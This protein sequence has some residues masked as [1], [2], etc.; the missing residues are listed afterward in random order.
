LKP[1]PDKLKGLRG[2]N[3]G[4]HQ[5]RLR[6]ADLGLTNGTRGLDVHD[7]PE[8]HVD[9][10]VVGVGKERRIAQRARPLR[11]TSLAAP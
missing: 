5:H 8:L 4:A 1:T 6:G 11:G 7:D 3:Q 9:E 2:T 10:I